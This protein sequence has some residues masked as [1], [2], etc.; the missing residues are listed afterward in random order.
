MKVIQPQVNN[1]R[2]PETTAVPGALMGAGTGMLAVGGNI[3]V[4]GAFGA[5]AIPAIIPVAICGAIG[6]AVLTALDK[7]LHKPVAY[8]PPA[9]EP[10]PE[11][12]P[13]STVHNCKVR[14]YE[15]DEITSLRQGHL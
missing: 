11:V 14:T 3:G 10:E 15:S 1:I 12:T 13:V 5:F 7:Q 4:A 8:L 6:A 9:A 2:Y